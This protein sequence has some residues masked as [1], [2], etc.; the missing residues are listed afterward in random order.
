MIKENPKFGNIICKCE[1]VSEA[2][3]LDAIHSPL[4]PH[5]LDSIKR[6][7]RPT[8]GHC[9]GGFCTLKVAKLISKELNIPLKDVLKETK[10]SYIFDNDDSMQ[11]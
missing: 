7:V 4:K 1:M 11:K 3:I 5:T 10:K 2:E 9:Q 6:R 8:A